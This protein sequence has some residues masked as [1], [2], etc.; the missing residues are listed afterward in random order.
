MLVKLDRP[1]GTMLT[2]FDKVELTQM[3]TR[4][5]SVTQSAFNYIDRFR[6]ILIAEDAV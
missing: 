3:A 1:G 4:L 5:T 2:A 6:M